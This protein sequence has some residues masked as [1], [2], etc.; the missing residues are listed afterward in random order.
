MRIPNLSI[1]VR[2]LNR[3]GQLLLQFQSLQL[4]CYVETNA[5]A[6]T[7]ASVLTQAE[8]LRMQRVKGPGPKDRSQQDS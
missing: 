2:L 7:K 3:C 4:A 1:P 6:Q 5:R 8:T